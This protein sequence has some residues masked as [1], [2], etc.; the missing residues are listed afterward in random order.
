MKTIKVILL[1]NTFVGKSCLLDCYRRNTNLLELSKQ[2]VN[3]ETK[4]LTTIGVDF[5]CKIETH[6]KETF[7]LQIWDTSGHERFRSITNSYFRGTNIA[8]I[9]CSSQNKKT[10]NSMK[11]WYN[12]FKNYN[13]EDDTIICFVFNDYK[14]MFPSDNDNDTVSFDD[15]KQLAKEIN[16]LIQVYSISCWD[17]TGVSDLFKEVGYQYY[18][19]IKDIDSYMLNTYQ[20]G[21]KVDSNDKMLAKN[22]EDGQKKCDLCLIS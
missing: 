6:N 19:S 7:K 15:V 2:N 21:I 16:P 17:G 1:G 13:Y 11:V 3:I 8:I 4:Y 20:S 5:L 22:V 14:H 10:L 9:M 12:T 18:Q